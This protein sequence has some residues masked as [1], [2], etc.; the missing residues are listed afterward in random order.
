[1]KQKKK[2]SSIFIFENKIQYVS[3]FCEIFH[4]T[5]NTISRRC[6]Q[7]TGLAKFNPQM[8]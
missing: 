8:G 1:M 6:P 4:H 3:R 5:S 7:K 2:L